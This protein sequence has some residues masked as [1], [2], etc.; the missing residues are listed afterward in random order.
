MHHPG[1]AVNRLDSMEN[2]HPLRYNQAYGVN[3]VAC[4]L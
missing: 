2:E 4:Y 3:Q 1:E